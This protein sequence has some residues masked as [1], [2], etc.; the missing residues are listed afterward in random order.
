MS[1]LAYAAGVRSA[2]QKLGVA[3][4]LLRH[5]AGPSAAG[6]AGGALYGGLQSLP[7]D[8]D[9]WA[10][11]K[12]RALRGAVAGPFVAGAYGVGKSTAGRFARKHN[13]N[14]NALPLIDVLGGITAGGGAELLLQPP[15][16]YMSDAL[17]PIYQEPLE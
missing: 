10:Q 11:V 7:E 12:G 14:Y 16:N 6:A 15:L 8:A 4:Q 2:Q 1:K 17:A 13:V 3:E 5:V 9:R